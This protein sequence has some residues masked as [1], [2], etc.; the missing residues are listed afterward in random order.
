MT[1]DNP[2]SETETKQ[3]VDRFFGLLK[4][5]N[6]NCP[7]AEK[8]GEGPGSCGGGK[9]SDNYIQSLIDKLDATDINSPKVTR[10]IANN[11]LDLAAQLHGEL[12]DKKASENQTQAALKLKKAWRDKYNSFKKV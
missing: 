10:E 12:I 1:T 6:L 4:Q 9:K 2:K 5:Y 8:I 7:D 3:I 11:M